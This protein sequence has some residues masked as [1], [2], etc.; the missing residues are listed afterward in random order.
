MP[1]G[2]KKQRL[3]IFLIKEGVTID[4]VL[5][6]DVGGLNR[7]DIRAGIDFTGVIFTKGT[8]ATPP[9]WQRFVQQGTATPAWPVAKPERFGAHTLERR[10]PVFCNCVWIRSPLDR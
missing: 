6:D 2:P 3:N 1:R 4:Q 8:P 7:H 10:R 9:S 5:R